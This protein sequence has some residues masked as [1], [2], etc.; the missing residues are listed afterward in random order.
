MERYPEHRFACSQ[1]QQFK[2][3]EQVTLSLS[4]MDKE[5]ERSAQYS[6]I[7][8]SLRGFKKR[9]RLGNSISSVVPGLKTTETCHLVRP[10]FGSLCTVSGTSSLGLVIDAKQLGCLIRSG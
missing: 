7:L 10:L 6:N 4:G 1:A 2:W 5:A 3:L 9:S 8:P